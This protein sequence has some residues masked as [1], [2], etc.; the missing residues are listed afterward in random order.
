MF[1]NETTRANAQAVLD[2]ITENPGLHDQLSYF[3]ATPCGTAMCIAGAALHLEYGVSG[4]MDVLSHDKIDSGL[5]LTMVAAPLLGLE[6][7]E[8]IDSIFYQYDN[9]KAIEKLKHIVVGDIETFMREAKEAY[10]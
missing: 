5:N 2:F 8:E 1:T 10:E 9:E 7:D 4:Y 6:T 3:R